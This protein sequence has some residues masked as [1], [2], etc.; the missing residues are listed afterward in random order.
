MAGSLLY[1]SYNAGFLCDIASWSTAFLF[2]LNPAGIWMQAVAQH[3]DKLS[4]VMESG[5]GD[6]S[7]FFQIISNSPAY[8]MIGKISPGPFQ[9]TPGLVC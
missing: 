1:F 3:S 9:N 7:I 4:I 6:L 5:S 8:Y 2:R